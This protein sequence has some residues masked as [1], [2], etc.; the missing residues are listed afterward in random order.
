MNRYDYVTTSIEEEKIRLEN[1]VKYMEE[2]SIEENYFEYKERYNNIC[3]YL[4]SKEKYLYIQ[5]S[6]KEDLDKI[7]NLKRLKDENELDNILLE[8][9]LLSKFHEDTNN[10]YR[11]ILYENIKNKDNSIRDILYLILI[12]ESNYKELMIKRSKLK[13]LLSSDLYPKTYNTLI[14]QELIIE[15]EEEILDNIYILENNIKVEKD[16]LKEL[17][18]SVMTK[19]ILQILYEFLIIDSYDINKINKNRLFIDNKKYKNIKDEI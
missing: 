5:N 14:S 4:N 7:E 9:T 8:D 2:N 13:E 6:I 19:S 11:N 15:A 17:E 10:I 18:S 16:K 3:L 1:I 12:K